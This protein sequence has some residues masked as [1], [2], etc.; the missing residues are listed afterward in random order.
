MGSV[1]ELGIVF[2]FFTYEESEVDAFLFCAAF[3]SAALVFFTSDAEGRLM[4]F[5]LEDFAVSVEGEAG[6][7]SSGTTDAV[8][9]VVSISS[10]AAKVLAGLAVSSGATV[11]VALTGSS[12]A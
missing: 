1:E 10:S 12:A 6:A 9:L 2:N 3:F 5:T 8:V 11:E 7:V 4:F